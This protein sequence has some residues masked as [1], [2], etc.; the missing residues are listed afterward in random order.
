MPLDLNDLHVQTPFK[1]KFMTRD[2][3][4]QNLT[5]VDAHMKGE[6]RD[7]SSVMSLYTDDIVL[8]MPTR[9][10]TLHGK[11]DIEANYRRMFGAMELISMTPIERFATFD[12]VIDDCIARFKLVREGFDAAPYPIGSTIDLRLLHVF[13][14]RDGK[15]ARETVFEGWTRI[16]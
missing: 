7:P 8:D 3:T 12:R 10:I 13:L 1:A 16:D 4:E 14:M 9:G 11:A 6:G 2:L 15:I 5:I